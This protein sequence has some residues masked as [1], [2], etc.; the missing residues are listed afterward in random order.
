MQGSGASSSMKMQGSGAS[1]SVKIRGSRV[2]SSAQVGVSKTDCSTR[3]AGTLAGRYKPWGAA[4]FGLAA[5][6]RLWVAMNGLNVILQNFAGMQA[7]SRPR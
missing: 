3:L 5:V 7:S 4:A 2:R 6:S 1:T